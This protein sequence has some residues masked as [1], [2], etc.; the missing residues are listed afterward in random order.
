MSSPSILQNHLNQQKTKE[1][2]SPRKWHSSYAPPD[3]IEGVEIKKASSPAY[4]V[5]LLFFFLHAEI[6][7]S[8]AK[9]DHI[10]ARIVSILAEI[11]IVV[12][13]IVAVFANKSFVIVYLAVT[14]LECYM[15][16]R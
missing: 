3:K 10:L 9:I 11:L 13:E 4:N 14:P 7:T 6:E 12:A 2:K 8:C 16:S 15:D 5:G 1:K